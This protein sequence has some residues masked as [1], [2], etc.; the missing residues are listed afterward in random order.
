MI[1]ANARVREPNPHIFNIVLEL[2]E[3]VAEKVVMVGV[4]WVKMFLGR[5]MRGYAASGPPCR[6]RARSECR[7]PSHDCAGRDDCEPVGTAGVWSE[8]R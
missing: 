4:C 3:V 1:S 5:I 8:N 2:L 7:P 6:P